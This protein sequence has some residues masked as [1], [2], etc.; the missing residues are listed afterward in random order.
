MEP[1]YKV[2][3]KVRVVIDFLPLGNRTD[4]Y[5]KGG[6]LKFSSKL[7]TVVRDG[8]LASG[9]GYLPDER[10]YLHFDEDP[11]PQTCWFDL[12]HVVPALFEMNKP[13]FTLEE[14][15]IAQELI[16]G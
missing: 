2:G 4:G 9:R 7:A 5:R 12:D 10:V 13:D 1:K 16:E 3:D 11:K 6:P 15:E 14:L 8:Y